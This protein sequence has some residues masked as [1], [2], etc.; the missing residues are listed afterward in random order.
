MI[1]S[2]WDRVQT[3]LNLKFCLKFLSSINFASRFVK[4]LEKNF[5]Q[6]KSMNL[7]AKLISENVFK[8]NFRFQ[9]PFNLS[10]S[11][12]VYILHVGSPTAGE[13]PLFVKKMS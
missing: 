6:I 5:E 10:I 4:R 2:L 9:N 7:N 12:F 13:N 3:A 11:Q 1:P 8:S